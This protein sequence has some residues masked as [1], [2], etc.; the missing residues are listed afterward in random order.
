MDSLPPGLG[1]VFSAFAK[2]LYIDYREK[3]K[4]NWEEEEFGIAVNGH[5]LSEIQNTLNSGLAPCS[6][7]A[8]S[9]D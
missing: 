4:G 2:D 6:L 5:I 3:Q 1:K 8:V 7:K 9:S